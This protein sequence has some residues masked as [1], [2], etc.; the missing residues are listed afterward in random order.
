MRFWKGCVEEKLNLVTRSPLRENGQASASQDCSAEPLMSA[1]KKPG[2]PRL[3]MSRAAWFWLDAEDQRLVM[4]EQRQ[5]KDDRQRDAKHPKQQTSSKAHW[6]LR[7]MFAIQTAPAREGSTITQQLNSALAST[8]PAQRRWSMLRV[9]Q[10]PLATDVRQGAPSRE[11]P[12]R[13]AR[14]RSQ[15]KRGPRR[16]APASGYRSPCRRSTLRACSRPAPR[17]NAWSSAGAASRRA[18]SE[19]PSSRHRR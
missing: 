2:G 10:S 1:I 12:T 18:A 15:T 16:S 11:S 3:K 17:R 8:T 4:P 14:R 19:E 9:P 13:R 5:Q 7:W 6:C